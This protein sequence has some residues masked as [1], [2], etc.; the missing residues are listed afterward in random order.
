M[1]YHNGT[2][3]REC[4]ALNS[5]RD[6]ANKLEIVQSFTKFSTLIVIVIHV[7]MY[8]LGYLHL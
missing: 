3:G 4:N 6:A 5:M 8:I 2:N 7:M 1:I